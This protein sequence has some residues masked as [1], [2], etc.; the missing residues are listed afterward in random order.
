MEIAPE[1]TVT[2]LSVSPNPCVTGATI[3]ISC[4]VE[5]YLEPLWWYC[6]NVQSGEV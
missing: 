4:V 2:Q 6:G 3:T 1:Y 5:D